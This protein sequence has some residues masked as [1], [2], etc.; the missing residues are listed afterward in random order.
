ML[1]QHE[2]R[3]QAFYADT[4]T[5]RYAARGH[6]DSAGNRKKPWGPRGRISLIDLDGSNALFPLADTPIRPYADTPT[7]LCPFPLPNGRVPQ[8]N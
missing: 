2:S 5:R 7:R 4:P 8:V 1:C 6:A 3:L